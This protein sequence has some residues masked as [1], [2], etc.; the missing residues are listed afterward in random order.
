LAEFT[1]PDPR[2]RR[3]L[4]I[5]INA[6]T[7]PTINNIWLLGSSPNS[8]PDTRQRNCLCA[9]AQ[10]LVVAIG[11]RLCW[12]QVE[13]RVGLGMTLISCSRAALE[14]ETRTSP[15]F[16]SDNDWGFVSF[17]TTSVWAVPAVRAVPFRT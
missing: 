10:G 5:A 8:H 1:P 16:R 6:V 17:G 9:Y 3:M 14:C 12:H 2:I 15:R 4:T 7:R 11:R 13:H